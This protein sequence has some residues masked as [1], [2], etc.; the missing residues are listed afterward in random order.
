MV[1]GYLTDWDLAKKRFPFHRILNADEISWRVLRNGTLT[2]T[3]TRADDVSCDF[4][5]DERTCITAMTAIGRDGRKLPLWVMA[6]GL[7]TRS[8]KRFTGDDRVARQVCRGNLHLVY[9]KSGW[10][11]QGVAIKYLKWLSSM[12][13]GQRQYPVPC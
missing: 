11:G 9:S 6:K 2:I 4:P 10:V 8:L 12:A 7:T 1:I 3:N 5:C 13:K